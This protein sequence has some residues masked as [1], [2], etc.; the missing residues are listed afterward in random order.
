MPVAN[1]CIW[2]L[3]R[4]PKTSLRLGAAFAI[5]LALFGAA[6][7]VTI[8]ALDRLD[9]ADSEVAELDDAKH[10][11]H[12]VAALVREQYIHQAHTIIEWNHSHLDHYDE[13]AREVRKATDHLE[14]AM[15]E[16][17]AR[18]LAEDIARLA[19]QVDADFRREILPLVGGARREAAVPVHARTERLVTRVVGLNEKLNSML[20]QDS[21]DA[22]AAQA[23]LRS[24]VRF[25]VMA[26][27]ALAL[28]AAAAIGAAITRS[29][30]RRLASVHRGA[31]RLADGDLS[32]RIEVV[33]RDEFADLGQAFNRMAAA[34]EAHQAQRLQAERL[35]SIGQVAAGVAHEINNPLCVILGYTKLLT[36]NAEDGPLRDGLATIEDEAR[37]C[38]RIVQ[39]LLEL[40]RPVRAASTAVDLLQVVRDAVEH[41]DEAGKLNGLEVALPEAKTS[42]W[43][44]GDAVHLRQVAA[45]LVQNAAEAANGAGERIVISVEQRDQTVELSVVDSGSGVPEG[46]LPHLF[47]PFFT[48][49]ARGTGLGLAISQAIAH[50]HGG[51]LS[52]ESTVGRGTRASLRL[53]AVH[54]PQA[55]AAE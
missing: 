9:A 47:E 6:L 48:T 34:V 8:H 53:P 23:T 32:S 50:A 30:A 28:A 18:A 35:A 17:D 52:I 38:Q 13:V 22:R 4:L 33:G 40:A 37:Q 43:V 1:L 7:G 25:A 12:A 26:C 24:R 41:L 11:A 15:R 45:N 10:S 3:N 16:P 55:E 5:V 21:A 31:A 19:A 49:K 39:G 44:A 2:M 46:I 42:A 29:I 27:F 36:R 54:P 14:S 51:E 20:E